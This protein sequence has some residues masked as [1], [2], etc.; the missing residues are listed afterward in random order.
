[1]LNALL[2]DYCHHF[3]QTA[4]C[5][6]YWP[7][8]RSLHF[9]F[10]SLLL[11]ILACFRHDSLII[12][13]RH[14][15]SLYIIDYF[16]RHFHITSSPD[17]LRH[18]KYI[19]SFHISLILRLHCTG[20]FITTPFRSS[21][22]FL[23]LPL[24]LITGFDYW[25]YCAFSDDIFFRLIYSFR[26]ILRFRAITPLILPAGCFRYVTLADIAGHFFCHWCRHHYFATLHATMMPLAAAIAITVIFIS[27]CLPPHCHL[28]DCYAAFIT[29]YIVISHWYDTLLLVFA[30]FHM[31]IAIIATRYFRH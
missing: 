29:H 13:L 28:Y 26:H 8:S 31:A 1:M 20:F 16:R 27:H 19:T 9:L 6:D 23:R 21:L 7:P 10:L 12:S 4:D 5:I 3:R 22:R 25:Y 2:T 18:I 17:T 24:S 15:F 14:F 30:Y 11:H